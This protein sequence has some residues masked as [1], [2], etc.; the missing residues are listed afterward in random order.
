MKMKNGFKEFVK[1]ELNARVVVGGTIDESELPHE[2]D[3]PVDMYGF[4]VS[5]MVNL[6]I[7]AS[8]V[9]GSKDDDK[10]IDFI[11]KISMLVMM[12]VVAIGGEKMANM[13]MR[14]IDNIQMKCDDE[15]RI[16]N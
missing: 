4:V 5:I 8:M 7:L 2:I 11:Q 1:E 13:D 3:S 6:L 10:M 9:K 12:M 14:H 16:D 15:D